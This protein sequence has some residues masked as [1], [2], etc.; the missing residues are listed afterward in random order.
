MNRPVL[1]VGLILLAF[2]STSAAAH[3]RVYKILA[4]RIP[5][6]ASS[7]GSGFVAMG[8]NGILTAL[9]VVVGADKI[10]AQ[11]DLGETLRDL[12]ICSVDVQRDMALLCNDSTG[13]LQQGAFPIA[14]QTLQPGDVVH[15]LGYPRLLRS[16]S[17]ELSTR[18]PALTELNSLIPGSD[19]G[20][21]SD[22]SS[23]SIDLQVYSLQGPLVPGLSGGPVI[24][25]QGDVDV[26][27]AIGSGGIDGGATDI[28]WAIPLQP[29]WSG[30]G[31]DTALTK[32]LVWVRAHQRQPLS[33]HATTA[34]DLPPSFPYEDTFVTRNG[35]QSAET[36]L[37]VDVHGQV[38]ATTVTRNQTTG[39]GYCT[40]LHVLFISRAN[41]PLK[42]LDQIPWCTCNG[43]EDFFNRM[44]GKQCPTTRTVSSAWTVEE[45]VLEATSKVVVMHSE[46]AKFPVDDWLNSPAGAE[47]IKAA[48]SLLAVP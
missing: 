32:L 41:K 6:S 42:V 33:L 8:Q 29:Q 7:Q 1:R 36:K 20:L 5:S 30:A 39:D 19:S 11:N 28:V 15:V 43:A 13:H 9:H 38:R 18:T 3:N 27:V 45:G 14:Q 35:K 22:R 12:R 16:L 21:F 2:V 25:R 34:E 24:L 44:L 48:R 23:P 40:S 46:E 10:V 37:N 17:T 26:V 47:V 31:T 4:Y